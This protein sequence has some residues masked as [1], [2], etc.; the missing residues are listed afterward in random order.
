MDTFFP[1]ETITVEKSSNNIPSEKS[2]CEPFLKPD[3]A[4]KVHET[5]LTGKLSI[6]IKNWE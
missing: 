6:N 3:D 2:E 5:E 1:E 4:G